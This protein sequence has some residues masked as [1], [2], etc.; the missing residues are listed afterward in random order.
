MNAIRPLEPVLFT[1]RLSE[2]NKKV[3]EESGLHY[4]EAPL[5]ASRLNQ[6]W[7]EAHQ[8][9]SS[10]EKANVV[11]TSRNGADALIAFLKHY[12][13]HRLKGSYY[14]VGMKTRNRLHNAG[15]LAY[16]PKIHDAKGLAEFM[17]EQSSRKERPAIFFHGNLALD[18]LPNR[19]EAAGIRVHKVLAYFT[20]LLTV[21][22]SELDYHS[23]AFMSPSAVEAF[24][25][26]GGFSSPANYVFNIG[27]TTAASAEN[28]VKD[29]IVLGGKQPSFEQL[30][31]LIMNYRDVLK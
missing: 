1:R 2:D 27:S 10:M 14:A 3:L 22:L 9:F 7:E 13:E 11:V 23:V 24:Q 19:L 16:K 30:V 5:I 17:I 4:V 15:I 18:T 8:L 26:N 6:D 12:P 31:K 25:K 21:D 20:D 28:F 29:A